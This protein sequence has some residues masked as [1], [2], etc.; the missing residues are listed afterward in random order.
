MLILKLPSLV[1]SIS[2]RHQ[3]AHLSRVQTLNPI[4]ILSSAFL[5]SSATACDR[6]VRYYSYEVNAPS[7]TFHAE[8]GSNAKRYSGCR[9]S[10]ISLGGLDA[11]VLYSQ[12]TGRG[13]LEAC[14]W[15]L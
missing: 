3:A 1:C 12:K 13:D 4:E 6:P 8:G 15:G 2:E 9:S 5:L 11:V 10:L 7:A 14:A